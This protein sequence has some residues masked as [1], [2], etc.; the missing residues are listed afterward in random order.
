MQQIDRDDSKKHLSVRAFLLVLGVCVALT[1]STFNYVFATCKE[2]VVKEDDKV[3]NVKT[4]KKTVEQVLKEQGI[5]VQP[6][7]ELQPIPNT[8]LEK[9]TEITIKRAVPVTI[10]CDGGEVQLMTCKKTLQ[11]VL[12]QASIQLNEKD[13]VNYSLTDQIVNGMK[14]AVTR[15]Q[16]D[17]VT[18]Q[19]RIPFNTV[20]KPNDTMEKGQKKLVKQGTE[21]LTEKQFSVVLHDGKE[22]SRELVNEN[23]VAQPQDQVFEY[24]T[25]AVAMTSRGETFRYNKVMDMRASAYDLS[26]QSCKK[27]PGDPSYGITASG[28][29]ARKGVV[30]VDPRVI[31]LGSRLYIEGVDGSWAYGYAIAGD[32]GSAIKGNA[33]DLFFDD[34]T[35]AKKFG[36][37][38]VK[39][40][41]IK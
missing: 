40:Y 36:R 41:V 32:T 29:K 28:M 38:K 15:V 6:Y 23:T 14:V 12:E 5:V 18:I 11:E 22:I 34:H 7:D 13:I 37:K 8:K 24:G 27:N 31:P 25:I 30:A 20:N 10:A 17:L 16:E 1:A 26:Y 9:N 2:I 39:V 35:Y 21:G 33:I 3:I 4:Y 19:E